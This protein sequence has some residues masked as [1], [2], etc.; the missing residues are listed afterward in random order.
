VIGTSCGKLTAAYC[1]IG[2]EE[3]VMYRPLALIVLMLVAA[4]A[5]ADR[6][7]TEDER[8]KL[9]S[10]MAAAGCSGGKMEFD[11]GKYEVDKAK[12]SDGRTYDLKFD[13]EFKLVKKELED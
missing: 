5:Y 2:T 12:C 6:P 3:H 1:S 7:V 11:D 9:L 13:A 10:A 8:T 4:S